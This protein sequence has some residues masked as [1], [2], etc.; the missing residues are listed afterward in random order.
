MHRRSLLITALGLS[1]GIS[2]SALAA[3]GRRALVIGNANYRQQPLKNPVN[4]AKAMMQALKG[5]DFEVQAVE[6]GSL[7][8]MVT[9]FQQ[10]SVKARDSSGV[11]VIFY[12]GHGMQVRGRNYL[13]PVDVEMISEGDVVRLSAD[14]GDLLE[15]LGDLREGM[16]IVILD[17]CRNNP[18]N[19]QPALD[20]DGRRIR[21]RSL[22]RQG[23]AP[24]EAPRGTIV[25][26]STAPGTVAIDSG[27]DANSVY[28][29]HL[30]KHIVEPGL[31]IEMLFKRV[32]AGVAQATQQLQIPWEA[33]S[34]T[35]NF[36]FSQMPG[37][38]CGP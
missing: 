7:R 25:A 11:R 37:K 15:R 17:A 16:N 28:T 6:N 19:N 23:L 18:F 3:E 10:F 4:D 9:A 5:L 35:G 24:V 8:D 31:H 21:T 2:S 26:Y 1:T 33:S 12:A 20:A 38:T 29:R 34:L 32:R 22:A 36:C 30:L 27:S 13:I 14:V